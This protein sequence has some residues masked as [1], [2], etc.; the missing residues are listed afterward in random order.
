MQ[1]RH[2][3]FNGKRQVGVLRNMPLRRVS[4]LGFLFS[5]HVVLIFTSF[6]PLILNRYAANME[7]DKFDFHPGKG[8]IRSPDA[9]SII[10]RKITNMRLCHLEYGGWVDQLHNNERLTSIEVHNSRTEDSDEFDYEF[11]TA[12]ARLENC[13]K[14]TTGDIPIPSNW[15]I[16]FRNLTTLDLLLLTVY[17]EPLQWIYTA[18]AVF[19]YMPAL[20]KLRLSSPTGLDFQQVIK[21]EEISEVAC[22]KLKDLNL[23]GHSPTGL[24]IAIGNQCS[25]LTTC[26]FSLYDINNEDLCALSKCQSIRH[27]SLD[28][29]NQI[30]NGLTYLTR[31][32]NL[33]KLHIQY[34]LGKYID[35]RLLLDFAHYCPRLDTIRLSDRNSQRRPS[36]PR[37]F[38]SEDVA[39]LF[40]AGAEL[41][42]YFEPRFRTPSPWDTEA[43]RLERLEEYLIRIDH[44]RR[45]I[46]ALTMSNGTSTFV[47]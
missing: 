45:D 6:N 23:G 13:R 38:E 44:I 2:H 11:W 16:Q 5:S 37:L 20:E 28:T 18:T 47:M 10:E 41:R 33:A 19:K 42:A 29:T 25:N 17:A 31:L 39:E 15:N 46:T 36:D 14:V 24:L 8:T 22:K 40:A 34:S 3:H 27:F 43:E 26:N 30:T 4:Q 9:M 35:T 32:P 12:I 1:L 7:L 21:M